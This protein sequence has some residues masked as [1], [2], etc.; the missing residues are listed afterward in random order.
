MRV[1]LYVV[2]KNDFSFIEEGMKLYTERIKRY[3][4]F[5]VFIIKKL[6]FINAEQV[7]KEEG[8]EILSK[9]KPSDIVVILDDKGKEFTSTAFA[10]FLE[11]KMA[12]GNKRLVFIIGGAYGF[13]EEVYLRSNEK[14]SLSKMTFS[15]QLIRLVFMEQIYRAFTIIKGEPYH[16]I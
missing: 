4:P 9:L 15:H 7:K 1:S 16:H 6:K 3:I 14:V 11:N 8:K 2:A 12:I 13:S 10:S 5:E